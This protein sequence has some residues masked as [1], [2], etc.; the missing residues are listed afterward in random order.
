MHHRDK[1]DYTFISE[2]IRKKPFY[3][4]RWFLKLS[5]TAG[6]AAV[7]GAVAAL[8]FAAVR[9][10]A[11]KMLGL[12]ESIQVVLWNETETDGTVTL[13]GE[14]SWDDGVLSG[15][16]SAA[17]ETAGADAQETEGISDLG[18]HAAEG[19]GALYE[20]VAQVAADA[21]SYMVTVTGEVSTLD[22]FQ[23]ADERRIQSTGLIIA[24]TD[25]AVFIY[26]ESEA[27]DDA[28]TITVTFTD[29]ESAAARLL[30]SDDTLG[31]AVIRV[32]LSSI[33]VRTRKELRTAVLFG[34]DSLKAGTPVIAAGS[35]LGHTDSLVFGQITS[36]TALSQVDG[37]YGFLTTD[38]IGSEEGS[39]ILLDL[40][41]NL[42][43]IIAQRFNEE[44]E[45]HIVCALAASDLRASVTNLTNG[46]TRAYL[47][48]RGR[49]ISET[50]SKELGMP[51][52]MFVREVA[53]GSP[54]MRAGVQKADIVT[55]FD[56]TKITNVADYVKALSEHEPG[57]KVV[58]TIRR[59]SMDTYV[60]VQEKITLG[61]K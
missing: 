1:Q 16:S 33:P 48:L 40:D 27:I 58:L 55:G 38:M 19:Y 23:E 44:E 49:D 43:G 6:L 61:E 57:D 46:T 21:D 52:G 41:G 26:T 22:L 10:W 35:P 50:V 56:G 31:V 53:D 30:K 18:A 25:S 60:S 24:R 45:E 7:F 15:G 54:A 8:S 20:T 28:E 2:E 9:P 13:T 32:S 3:R 51:E 39:G 47:G 29:G 4:Q 59:K 36:V 5:G 11:Q 12:N 42:V 14:G 34:A 17:A 37:Q